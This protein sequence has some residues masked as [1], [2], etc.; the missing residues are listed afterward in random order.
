MWNDNGLSCCH[1]R[2]LFPVVWPDHDRICC[3]KASNVQRENLGLGGGR[4]S[5]VA[6]ANYQFEGFAGDYT[7]DVYLAT[8]EETVAVEWDRHT[9]VGAV[10]EL[11]LGEVIRIK[12]SRRPNQR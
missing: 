2:W 6:D 11:Y 12:I 5:F 4:V 9:K 8:L 3:A 10:G 1:D 7:R